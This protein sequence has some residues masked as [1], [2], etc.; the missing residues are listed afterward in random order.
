MISSH[1]NINDFNY[2]M[3]LFDINIDKYETNRCQQSKKRVN[4]NLF[5]QYLRFELFH[6]F[7][8]FSNKY[9]NKD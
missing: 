9:I 8:I 2:C 6:F 5:L 3:Q 4:Y 1:G 7:F